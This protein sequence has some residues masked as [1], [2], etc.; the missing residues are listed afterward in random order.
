MITNKQFDLPMSMDLEIRTI[1]ALMNIGDPSNKLAQQC[2]L[3]LEEDYFYNPNTKDLFKI[4]K[5]QFDERQ[6]FDA[7]S[8]SALVEI[9]R[10]EFFQ[11]TLRDEYFTSN[12][13][14][15]D[16]EQL[17]NYRLL[18]KQLKVISTTL[19]HALNETIPS[20][21]L[22][23][24]SE[25]L[26]QLSS[27]TT[28]H[29]DIIR[30]YESITDDILSGGDETSFTE[31]NIPGLPPVPENA[32]IVI[33]GRS[34]HGKTFL[35]LEFMDKLIDAIP[36][37][38]C[39]YFNLEMAEEIMIERHATLL[40]HKGTTRKELIK[41]ALPDL[42]KKNVSLITVPM[43]TIEEIETQARLASL[44][45][46]L[47]V[48]VVDYLN[49]V[50]CKVKAES[51]HSEQS[52]IAKRL[53][54]LTIELDCRVIVPLQVNRASSTR[55]IDDRVPQVADAADSMGSVRSATWW[56]G[57][58]QPQNDD[59]SGEYK[60]LFQIACR[61]NRHGSNFY[62]DLDFKNG[63]FFKREKRFSDMQPKSYGSGMRKTEF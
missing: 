6:N 41:S 35:S 50:K 38:Q 49:L 45:Q 52:E 12:L 46:P 10:F 18:R 61:K 16:I 37:K 19:D 57:I 25:C 11:H 8:I 27:V 28:K 60:D 14:T 2:L 9:H 39:L 58:N 30:T 47:S 26:Q 24:I 23:I 21:S 7:V 5:K 56:I 59:F 22:G 62:F 42:M 40:G 4:I 34:G 17:N 32:L 43:I 29:R 20:H 36:D 48:I 15:H 44:R 33:A 63:M 55:P 1:G 31:I 3:Q 51:N 54:A 13:L 53:A